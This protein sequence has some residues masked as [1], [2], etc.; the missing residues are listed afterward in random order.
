MSLNKSVESFDTHMRTYPEQ[1]EI[2]VAKIYI[3]AELRKTYIS[4][5]LKMFLS[6]HKS[7]GSYVLIEWLVSS[8]QA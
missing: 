5:V 7:K 2:I 3:I 8:I 6:Q 4:V 1:C